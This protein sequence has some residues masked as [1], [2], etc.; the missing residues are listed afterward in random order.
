[1]KIKYE[2]K[3]IE[4]E[5]IDV[6]NIKK[7]YGEVFSKGLDKLLNAIDVAESAYDIKC[8]PQYRMHLLKGNLEGVYSLSPDNKKSKWRVPAMCLDAYDKAQKPNANL[9]EIDLLK[10]LESFK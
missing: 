1:M 8:L 2:T 9:E 5:Y 10:K 4:K 7:K 6:R 3:K